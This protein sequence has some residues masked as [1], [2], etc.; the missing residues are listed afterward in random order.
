[1][2]VS[3]KCEETANCLKV[4]TSFIND[5][6]LKWFLSYFQ[7]ETFDFDKSDRMCNEYYRN[8]LYVKK[9]SVRLPQKGNVRMENVE[10]CVVC[11]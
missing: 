7:I 9:G 6:S 5:N 4:N 11:D 10:Q 2:I 1:M 8:H 3:H